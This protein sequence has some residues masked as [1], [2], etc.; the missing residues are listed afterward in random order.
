MSTDSQVLFISPIIIYIIITLKKYIL[1]VSQAV[2][3]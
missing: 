1:S 3:L 2:I